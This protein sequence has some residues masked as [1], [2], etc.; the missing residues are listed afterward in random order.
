[1]TTPNINIPDDILGLPPAARLRALRHLL[2][3]AVRQTQTADRKWNAKNVQVNRW[4]DDTGKTDILKR[5]SI[6]KENLTLQEHF[7]MQ[8]WWREQAVYLAT[9]IQTELMLQDAQ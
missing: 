2:R 6:K 1:M 7:A 4:L 9:L 3:E 5:V 8:Q